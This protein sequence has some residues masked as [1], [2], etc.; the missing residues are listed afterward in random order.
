[1][2]ISIPKVRLKKLVSQKK[3]FFFRLKKPKEIKKNPQRNKKKFINIQKEEGKENYFKKWKKTSNLT[4]ILKKKFGR[5]SQDP[6]NIK[7][8]SC[9]KLQPK[10]WRLKTRKPR[11][12]SVLISNRRTHFTEDSKSKTGLFFNPPKRLSTTAQNSFLK[13][14][15][16]KKKKTARPQSSNIFKIKK[17]SISKTNQSLEKKKPPIRL[18]IEKPQAPMSK[19]PFSPNLSVLKKIKYFN[20]I[21]MF[22]FCKKYLKPHAK[23]IE[24]FESVFYNM[25]EIGRGS[26]A[27]AYS[28][29]KKDGNDELVLKTLRLSKLSRFN[30]IKRL[31]VPE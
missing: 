23:E 11:W 5:E 2:K 8:D 17:K 31:M 21:N 18:E 6:S 27:V 20:N 28:V 24:L 14:F 29:R 26:Y 4:F 19:D 13:S 22:S 7:L 3:S 12:V 10:S 25:K 30:K 9:S 16:K 1:M 15:L